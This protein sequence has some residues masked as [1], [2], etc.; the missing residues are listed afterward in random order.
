MIDF[1]MLGDFFFVIIITKKFTEHHKVN[2]SWI[3]AISIE[4]KF[5]NEYKSW[6]TGPFYI[7]EIFYIEMVEQQTQKQIIF[8]SWTVK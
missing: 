8:Y 5:Q 7:E 1:M 6:L 2:H 3:Y 4:M